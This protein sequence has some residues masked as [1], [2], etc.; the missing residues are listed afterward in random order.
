MSADL[1]DIRDYERRAKRALDTIAKCLHAD[2]YK[3]IFPP[4]CKTGSSQKPCQACTKKWEEAQL[5]FG[6]SGIR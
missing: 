5:H 2:D 4:H 6:K 1:Y 3:A